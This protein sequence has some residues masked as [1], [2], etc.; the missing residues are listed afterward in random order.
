MKLILLA[1]GFA[2]FK[3]KKVG[4]DWDIVEDESDIGKPKF[5]LYTG[6]ETIEEKEIVRN[7]YNGA[8]DFVPVTIANKLKDRY[9]NNVYGDAI[10]V[11]MITSSGAEG[12]NLKNTRFVHIVEPYWHMVRV[13]QVVGRAR[14]I[15]SHQELPEELRTVKVFLYISTLSEEQRTDDKNIELRIRDV[16]RIDKSTPITTDENLYEIASIKQRINNDFLHAIKETAIDCTLYS[17]TKSSKDRP[18]VC[19]GLGKFETN[20][21]NSYPSFELDQQ[22]KEGLDVTVTEMNVREIP[23]TEYVV[24]MD[25]LEIYKKDDYEYAATIPGTLPTVIGKV[26]IDNGRKK[27]VFNK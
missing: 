11:F 17:N 23:G 13:D 5:V 20:A 27:I 4:D 22:Q 21:F 3:I 6:T 8:W 14:R 1:N 19:Y 7:V 15:C 10:K 24:N 12:I 9:D 18:V 26:V 16:S 25:S 2:E